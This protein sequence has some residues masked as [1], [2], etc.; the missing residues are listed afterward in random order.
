MDV[1]L[2]QETQVEPRNGNGLVLRQRPWTGNGQ[3]K[4]IRLGTINATTLNGKEEEVVEMMKERNLDLLGVCETRMPGQGSKVIHED[5]QLIF[6]GRDQERKYGVAF[7]M[8]QELAN[9]IEKIDY[10]NERIILVTIKLHARKI[11]LIEVYAPHQGRPQEEKDAFYQ[12]LQDTLDLSA[13]GDKIVLGDLNAHVGMERTGVREVLGAFGAGDRN[14]EGEVLI[15][16]CLRNELSI[17]N[18]YYKHQDSHK[19]SWYRWDSEI[20]DY[21]QKSMIDFFIT[22]N[23][24]VFRDVKSVPSISLDSDHRLVLAKLSIKNP[25]RQRKVLKERFCL[26]RLKEREVADEF[27]SKIRSLKPEENDDIEDI[28]TEWENFKSK[29]TAGAREVVH[30]KKIGG[31]K[32]KK[33]IWWTDDVREAI[34]RKSILFRRWMRRR[35]EITREAYIEAR[36]EAERI[37][38][39]AKKQAWEKIGDELEQDMQGTRKL[40]YSIARNYRKRE[41][42]TVRSIKDKEG[43]L[44]TDQEEIDERW[45]EYFSDLLGMPDELYNLELDEE[46]IIL[47]ETVEENYITREEI[48][49]ALKEMKKGKSPGCDEIPA[50]LLSGSDDMI[51]WLHRLFSLAWNEGNV[52]EEWG[53]AIVCPIYKRMIKEIARIIGEFLC[54][55]TQGKYMK[56]YWKED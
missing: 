6:K 7:I 42:P 30:T 29:V 17:M 16:F 33:T 45:R 37:K 2:A 28:E 11:T 24:K 51:D 48:K 5:Y 49:L 32:K 50:E 23:K 43:V 3:V 36:N 38:R 8:T 55:L 40:I 41:E 14:G 54:L 31:G 34:K 39:E 12:T 26:E 25:K 18:T 4:G 47:E 22:N 10:V 1:Y 9:R 35:S 20:G 53:K 13:D 44:L 27:R 19:W 52:P 56:G 46:D 21:T 15:D